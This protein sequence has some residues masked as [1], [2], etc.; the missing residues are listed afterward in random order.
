MGL[1]SFVF[2]K[3]YLFFLLFWVLDLLNS[4]EIAIFAKYTEYSGEY[5]IEFILIYVICLNLGELLS[6]FLVLYTKLKMNYLKGIETRKDSKK[7]NKTYL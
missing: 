7:K 5:Q 4:L 6:G 3:A 1:I 2:R